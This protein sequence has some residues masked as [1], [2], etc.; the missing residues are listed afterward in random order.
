[1]FN[2]KNLEQ[3]FN[4][5]FLISDTDLD[6]GGAVTIA[7]ILYPDMDFATPQ[8]DDI[9][10]TLK[11]AIL[12][13]KY[14]T[15]LM[16]DCSPTGEDTIELINKFVAE[17]NDFVLLD[18]HKTALELNKYAWSRVKVET[19]GHKHSGTELL[20]LFLKE[21]GVDV[22]KF[23]EFVELVRCYDTWDWFDKGI[24]EAEKLNKL[25]YFLGLERFIMNIA[26]K[27][28]NNETL[29]DKED[30]I[31]LKTIDSLD[32]QYIKEHKTMFETIEYDGMKVGVL[33]TD[34]C[35]SQLGN[36][37]CRENPE[38]DFCCLVDLNKNK[39]SMRSLV[40]K[41]DVSVIAKKF[42]GGGHA[43][44][45]GFSLNSK[46]KEELLKVLFN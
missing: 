15:I 32:N 44:A 16:T 21:I 6:G 30:D 33:F 28:Y 7:K 35:V 5:A 3:K 37:I 23:S 38:L 36:I 39:C 40:G 24:Q 11:E 18:H 4:K 26:W 17:G 2:C 20:Y 19:N 14:N 42:G 27:I 10:D 12:S 43:Q 46:A 22:S 29:F 13:S 31:I 34:K 45:S 41:A 25:Y 9:N 8:R 1:M